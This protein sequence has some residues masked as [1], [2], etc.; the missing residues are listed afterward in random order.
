M[1]KLSDFKFK[2]M[3]IPLRFGSQNEIFAQN[4]TK[5]KEFLELNGFKYVQDINEKYWTY[6]LFDSANTEISYK[7]L[8]KEVKKILPNAEISQDFIAFEKI[9]GSI[10]N[11]TPSEEN[12]TIFDCISILV[13]S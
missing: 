7:N 11:P 10:L 6:S 2:E 13:F 5:I 4:Q 1:K 9:E 8:K 3:S 12:S